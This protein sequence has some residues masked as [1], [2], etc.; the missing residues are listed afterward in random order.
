MTTTVIT[1]KGQIVI[2]A[3]IRKHLNI[4]AG[5][6]LNVFEQ[7]GQIVIQ[8]LTRGYFERMAGMAAG[9][10]SL[11]KILFEEKAREKRREDAKLRRF[12]V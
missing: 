1:S 12:G 5:T 6:R 10:G 11:T 9:K 3:A 7:G 8:P 4:G 2:P